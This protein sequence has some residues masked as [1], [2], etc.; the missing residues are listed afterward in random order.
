MR[1]LPGRHLASLV[2]VSVLCGWGFADARPPEK[3]SDDLYRLGQAFLRALYPELNGKRYIVTIESSVPFDDPAPTAYWFML[4]VGEGAKFTI[5][6]CCLGGYMGEI[7]PAPGPPPPEGTP[8]YTPAPVAPKKPPIRNPDIDE[9]G[10]EH[11]RQYLSA[12]FTFD[13]QGRLKDFTAEGRAISDR[14]A[15]EKIAEIVSAHPEWTEAQVIAAVKEN[16][17][18]YGPNDREEFTKN[19]PF[20]K[21]EPFLGRLKLESVSFEPLDDRQTG[22]SSWPTWTVEASAKQKDGSVLHYRMYFDHRDGKL[23]GLHLIPPSPKKL[24]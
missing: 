18:K 10:A 8:P 17:T 14:E 23:F 24:P 4:T 6:S 2:I 13:R 12:G 3:A 22:M 9:R 21:L 7:I 16:G 1:T 20:Q 19:L 11:F 15:D 5:K